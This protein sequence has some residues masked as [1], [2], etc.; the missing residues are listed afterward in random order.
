MK[1]EQRFNQHL[2]GGGKIVAAANVTD[3]MDEDGIQL[4]GREALRDA[5]RN[6][7]YGPEETENARFEAPIARGQDG[8]TIDH[9][10]CRCSARNSAYP[11]PAQPPVGRYY[12]NSAA[13]QDQEQQGKRIPARRQG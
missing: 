6:K 5:F 1:P 11:T 9:H 3:F 13:P 8:N 2:N 7:Y 4:L 12:H 10:H